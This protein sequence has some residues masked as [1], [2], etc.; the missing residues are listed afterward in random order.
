MSEFD[1]LC[2]PVQVMCPVQMMT[3]TLSHANKWIANKWIVGN[4]S[5]P[6]K[7]PLREPPYNDS[8]EEQAA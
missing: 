3:N 2:C 8:I 7:P 6:K 4:P 1:T 5:T